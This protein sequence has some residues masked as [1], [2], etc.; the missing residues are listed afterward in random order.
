MQEI[1]STEGVKRER[2]V[3]NRVWIGLLAFSL[4]VMLAIDCVLLYLLATGWKPDRTII[5][6]LL[7][8]MLTWSIYRALRR[9]IAIMGAD[10][11]PGF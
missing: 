7:P 3:G 9:R 11:F 4:A 5:G 1:E 10:K 6:I 8:L 2:T